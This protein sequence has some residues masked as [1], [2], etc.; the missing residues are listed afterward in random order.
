MIYIFTILSLLEK[1]NSIKKNTTFFFTY[2]KK[3]FLL[4]QQNIFV[5][6]LRIKFVFQNSIVKHN[7][8]YD[9]TKKLFLKIVF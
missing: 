2:S 9:N 3:L 6:F 4:T 7:F 8:V 1:K 5:F